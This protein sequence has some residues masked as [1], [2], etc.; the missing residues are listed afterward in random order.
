MIRCFSPHSFLS[1]A[2][3]FPLGRNTLQSSAVCKVHSVLVF[4]IW[5][6]ARIAVGASSMAGLVCSKSG[7][8]QVLLE[9]EV[10]QVKLLDSVND[11]FGGVIVELSEAMDLKVF[12][13]MLK[14]SIALWRSQSKRGVWIK[15]P[16]Q[17]VNLVEAAVKEGFWFHHAEPK[18]LMLAFWIPEGSHTLPAN[19]SHRVSIGAFVMNKKREVLVV[20]EKCGIFRGTG[21][22]KLPTGA[23]D[24]GEDICAGAIREVKEETAIDTEF[25]EVL[26]FWQSHK[27][28]FGK[29]DLFFVCM[30]RPL[31]FDIQ[32]QES[33]IE[34]A[35]WMPW[36]DYVAQPFVQKHELSKQLVDICKAKEDETYF[37]FSPVP[38]ASKLPDQKSFLYLNDRDLEGSEV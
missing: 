23:V 4:G 32:K 22:W 18:Y 15:V 21:I 24:E 37:G 3:I 13:S 8:E 25:V 5:V 1:S 19:A 38:I 12:A 6:R 29:S 7:M 35:Q 36:D 10:Q 31:S 20:Q 11:D 30:L 14:A 16:I 34:D 26:A 28:F 33:E 9:N 2:V 27:S 17:L